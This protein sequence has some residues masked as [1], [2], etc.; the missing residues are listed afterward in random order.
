MGN[1]E[2]SL[3]NRHISFNVLNNTQWIKYSN[4]A[5]L[6]SYVKVLIQRVR[7]IINE[8]EYRKQ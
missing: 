4:E 6:E 5:V 7:Q 1:T 2:R 3:T 8:N